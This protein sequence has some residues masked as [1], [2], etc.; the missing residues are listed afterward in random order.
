SFF[1]QLSEEI[2]PQMGFLDSAAVIASLDLV[3]TVDT[4]MGHLGGALGKPVW[5]AL[6]AVSDWRWLRERNDTP[7]YATMRLFSQKALDDWDGV[8]ASMAGELRKILSKRTRGVVRIEVPPGELLDRLTI[9][10]LKAQRINDASKLAHIRVEL[11][12]LEDGLRGQVPGWKEAEALIE[13][14][15]DINGRLWDVEDRL[16]DCERAGD[17]G[18]AFVRLA[19]S[20]YQLNDR[21]GALKREL[22]ERLGAA[23]L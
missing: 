16:R 1:R 18:E 21:R 6:S 19:R 10:R 9:A 14:L 2:D 3:V 4:A 13:Q 17:F 12:A 11:A 8:F 22:S 15:Q 7:W 5:L 23:W 20:V